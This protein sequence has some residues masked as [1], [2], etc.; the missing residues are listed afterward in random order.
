MGIIFR[1]PETPVLHNLGPATFEEDTI[2]GRASVHLA[3]G[4]RVDVSKMMMMV[5]VTGDEGP[6]VLMHPQ[7]EG[8]VVKYMRHLSADLLTWADNI[9][10]RTAD[11][12][13]VGREIPRPG[14]G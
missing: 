10:A 1:D 4:A 6:R 5:V 3:G 13:N 12:G 2:A 9:E 8:E 11:G 14:Q 7:F